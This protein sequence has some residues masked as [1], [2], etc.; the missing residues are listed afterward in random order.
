MVQSRAHKPSRPSSLSGSRHVHPP[1]R[2]RCTLKSSHVFSAPA[3]PSESSDLPVQD[4]SYQWNHTLCV[5]LCLLFSLSSVCS[6]SSHA[7]ACVRAS[8]FFHD[9]VIFHLTSGLQALNLNCSSS[10]P[11]W[12]GGRRFPFS[13]PRKQTHKRKEAEFSRWSTESQS[14]HPAK[15]KRGRNLSENVGREGMRLQERQR[16]EDMGNSLAGRSVD[17]DP[18]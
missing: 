5:L 10:A 11:S 15:R 3:V 4:V 17:A 9:R 16:R 18:S 8:L 12:V 13:S 2:R 1:Q 7:V 14:N 6:G